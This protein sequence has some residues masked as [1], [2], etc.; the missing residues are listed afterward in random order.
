VDALLW[1]L[2]A[3]FVALV[4]L[5]IVAWWL[6][7]RVARPPQALVQR[8]G[9][10]P[11][12]AKAGLALA[13]LR[14]PRLPLITRLIIPAVVLYL[15]LPIDIIPD[16]I[17]LLGQLDDVLV[18]LVALRLVLRSMPEGL[19][20]EHIARLEQLHQKLPAGEGPIR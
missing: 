17:P 1:T 4:L 8:I 15:A 20:E 18:L 12:R 6:L 11:W 3:V 16:F 7:R 9:K 2:V 10:L 13:L 14:D 19:L 5:T